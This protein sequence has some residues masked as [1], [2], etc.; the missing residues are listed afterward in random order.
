VP[1]FGRRQQIF[2]LHAGVES[3]K[4]GKVIRGQTHDLGWWSMGGIV[5]TS[6]LAVDHAA[7]RSPHFVVRVLGETLRA[8]HKEKRVL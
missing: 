6:Y 7:A 4:A 8:A 2:K 5:D 3:G 1:L